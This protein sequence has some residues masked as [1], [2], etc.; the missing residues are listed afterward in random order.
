MPFNRERGWA[1]AAFVHPIA[2]TKAEV[3]AEAK[4]RETWADC[5]TVISNGFDLRKAYISYQVLVTGPT[6]EPEAPVG[7]K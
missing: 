7:A 2:T 3:A 5:K 4:S 1:K 6:P